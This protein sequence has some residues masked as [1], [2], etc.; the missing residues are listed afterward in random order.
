MKIHPVGAQLFGAGRRTD[1]QIYRRTHT[2][3]LI[4]AFRNFVKASRTIVQIN[5]P[6]HVYYLWVC[7][8]RLYVAFSGF[9]V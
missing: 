7:K 4:V 5:D 8:T 2:T 9:Q 3:K 1:G 6:S